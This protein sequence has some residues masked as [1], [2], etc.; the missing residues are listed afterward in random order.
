S[1]LDVDASSSKSSFLAVFNA[2]SDDQLEQI[3]EEDLAL[4]ANRIA[5]AMNNARNKKRGGPNRCFECGSI[6]HL[7]S[8][9]PKLGRGKREDKDGEKT[10]NNKP[11]NNKSKGSH[12]RR[13]MEN[14]RKAFQQVC[15]AFE[16]LSDV[17]GESGDDDKGKN[18]SD[19]CF[20][21][22]GESDT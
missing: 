12:Q 17:D 15:A 6:D 21:A 10:N 18:V 4:V 5:R 13:K 20:M 16:P 19:V 14:L 8:H 11:N 3:E 2:T 7:R 1:S 22:R 9:C